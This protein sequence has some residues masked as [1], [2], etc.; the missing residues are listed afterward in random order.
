MCLV[1]V[2]PSHKIRATVSDLTNPSVVATP[3]CVTT[4]SLS[5]I[6][7]VFQ[8]YFAVEENARILPWLTKII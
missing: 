1:C 5:S 7:F 8:W 3:V 6:D 2:P 4:E